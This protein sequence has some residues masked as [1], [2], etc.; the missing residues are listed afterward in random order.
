MVEIGFAIGA[1]TSIARPMITGTDSDL[2]EIYNVTDF[3]PEVAKEDADDAL[4][5]DPY[6]LDPLISS[7]TTRTQT[8]INPVTN[9]NTKHAATKEFRTRQYIAQR[10]PR[11]CYIPTDMTIADFFTKA[12]TETPFCKFRAFLGMSE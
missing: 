3:A 5:S 7:T 8:V 1:R 12:L 10:L 11:V 9:S 2:P 4:D 6:S